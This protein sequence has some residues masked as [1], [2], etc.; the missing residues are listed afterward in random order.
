MLG[1]KPTCCQCLNKGTEIGS[2]FTVETFF[3]RLKGIEVM[4]IWLL[5]TL[6]K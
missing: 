1:V 4:C 2:G 6:S 3:N 5:A